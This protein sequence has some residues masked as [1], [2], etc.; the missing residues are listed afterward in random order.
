MKNA[1]ENTELE[2]TGEE[3]C[4]ACAAMEAKHSAAFKAQSMAMHEAIKQKA[5]ELFAT[6]QRFDVGTE[7]KS[8]ALVYAASVILNSVIMKSVDSGRH[9]AEALDMVI[10]L[11]ADNVTS[12]LKACLTNDADV[13]RTYVH[14]DGTIEHDH[15]TVH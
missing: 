10:E 9:P 12:L 3:D 8:R 2:H 15:G 7:N 11:T 14:Q 5:T 1:N 13:E 6:I 4:P